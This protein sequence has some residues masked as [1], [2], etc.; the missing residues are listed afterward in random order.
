VVGFLAP[1]TTDKIKIVPASTLNEV[2]HF[3]SQPFS[4]IIRKFMNIGWQNMNPVRP[5]D[6]QSM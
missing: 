3:I 1:E 4:K 2:H 6:N 5:D